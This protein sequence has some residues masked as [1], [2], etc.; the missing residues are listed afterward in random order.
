MFVYTLRNGSVALVDEA[1]TSGEWRQSTGL[2]IVRGIPFLKGGEY[3]NPIQIVRVSRLVFFKETLTSA[4]V[5]KS[6]QSLSS[7]L[8]LWL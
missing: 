6:E 4:C 7:T 8:E 2:G 3:V 1:G 5:S